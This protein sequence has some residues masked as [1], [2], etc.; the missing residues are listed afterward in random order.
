MDGQSAD[1]ALVQNEQFLKKAYGKALLPCM[2][3][4]IGVHR[5]DAG[6][7]AVF[8]RLGPFRVLQRSLTDS[9]V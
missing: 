9:V 8:V 6:D 5:R 7:A 3:S 4:I 1:T 2:L